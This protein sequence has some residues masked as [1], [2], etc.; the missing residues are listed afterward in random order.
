[1]IPFLFSVYCVLHGLCLGPNGWTSNGKTDTQIHAQT[2][3]QKSWGQVPRE[4]SDEMVPTAAAT[5]TQAGL[6]YTT[7]GMGLASLVKRLQG[8][9]P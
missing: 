7:Q 4:H 5:T 9:Q 1:M 8:K 6:L 2:H 3:I